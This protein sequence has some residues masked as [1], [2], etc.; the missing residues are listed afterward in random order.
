M[1]YSYVVLL[2]KLTVERGAEDIS[3]TKR[4]EMLWTLG[5]CV[6]GVVIKSSALVECQADKNTDGKVRSGRKSGVPK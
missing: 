2:K 3:S 6:D 5:E 4:R 1:W